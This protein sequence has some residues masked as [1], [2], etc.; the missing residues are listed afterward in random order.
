M[1]RLEIEDSSTVRKAEKVF[2][3]RKA[4]RGTD[5]DAA[6]KDSSANF[7]GGRHQ[8]SDAKQT[9]LA[10]T[11]GG[12]DVMKLLAGFG[13]GTGSSGSGAALA[14]EN[15]KT[16]DQEAEAAP[17]GHHEDFGSS[18]EEDRA[19]A[20][21]K[22]KTALLSDLCGV[23]VPQNMRK[24]FA[25]SDDKKA[26]TQRTPGKAA[27]KQLKIAQS[28]TVQLTVR[29]PAGAA[30]VTSA[31][32]AAREADSKDC[33]ELTKPGLK[34]HGFDDPQQYVRGNGG[35]EFE[36]LFQKCMDDIENA[37]LLDDFGTGE[38]DVVKLMVPM[39][40]KF[41]D[42]NTGFNKVFWKI[43]KRETIC[44]EKVMPVLESLSVQYRCAVSAYS[45]FAQV[46][47]DRQTDA[48]KFE[49]LYQQ[50][51][52]RLENLK[53]RFKRALYRSR[54]ESMIM[55][56][57]FDDLR[58]FILA[59]QFKF[60]SQASKWISLNCE[61]FEVSLQELCDAVSDTGPK[62]YGM[63]AKAIQFIKC[64]LAMEGVGKSS[65]TAS[66]RRAV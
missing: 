66:S 34:A 23:S 52:G 4:I 42:V 10:L 17:S 54:V 65:A 60:S 3:S 35:K 13:G 58:Q 18:S 64:C 40:A 51:G 8:I 63:L 53:I 47:F 59:E 56:A 12:A 20:A 19:P 48:D 55:F 29:S 37:A 57:Q 36:S 27:K 45:C 26:G 50:M 7:L 31:E 41:K 9:P 28:P 38:E 21:E 32:T 5:V 16:E 46:G 25:D 24:H 39:Q 15:D 30:P 33:S 49:Q 44:K 11:S 43:K 1:F 62:G 14:L 6:F 2:D 22:S 61:I